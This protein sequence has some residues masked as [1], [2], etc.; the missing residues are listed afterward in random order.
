M[1]TSDKCRSNGRQP[2]KKKLELDTIDAPKG[3]LAATQSL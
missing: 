3:W 2:G 1:L